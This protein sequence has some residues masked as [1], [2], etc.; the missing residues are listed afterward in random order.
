MGGCG[1]LCRTA[2]GC[3]AHQP[4]RDGTTRYEQPNQNTSTSSPTL[5]PSAIQ[6]E[7]PSLFDAAIDRFQMRYYRN[8]RAIN[9]NYCMRSN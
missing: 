7:W 1:R 4:R 2:I 6:R 5:N 3:S 8:G 9:V